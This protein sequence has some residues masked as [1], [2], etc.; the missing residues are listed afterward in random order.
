MPYN[1]EKIKVKVWKARGLANALTICRI[2]LS[3]AL[4]IPVALSPAF[5][6]IYTIAGLTDML[7]GFVARRTGTESKLGAM[8]DSVADLILVIVCLVKIL[9]VVSMPPWLWIWV[10]AIAV[11]KIANVISG[12]VVAKRMVMLHTTAN[13]VAGL[14]TFLVPFAI[15]FFGI[16]APAIPA[17][18]AATFA[19]VQEGHFIRTGSA[20]IININHKI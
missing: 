14:V 16:V 12:F 17:C 1:I 7:D 10:A 2:A 19:A 4:L 5:L 8:L 20:V 9:P 11:V 6:I 15:P 18:A 3:V 13:K